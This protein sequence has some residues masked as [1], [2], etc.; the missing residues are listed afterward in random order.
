[1]AAADNLFPVNNLAHFLFKQISVWLNDT[2]ISPQTDTYHYKAYLETFLNYDRED[3]ETMLKPQG[4][5]SSIDLPASLTANNLDTA[6]NAGAGHNNFQ[7]LSTNQ[8]ANVKLMKEEQAS[9]TEGKTAHRSV[10]PQK[11]VST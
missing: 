7:R 10:P 11:V 6:T 8:E 9:Y 5:Y 4:W 1:M 2:L 3:G